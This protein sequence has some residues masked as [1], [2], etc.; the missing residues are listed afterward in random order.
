MPAKIQNVQRCK[1]H[2][3]Y[4]K[5]CPPQA[6]LDAAQQEV[7]A[8]K[9][10]LEAATLQPPDGGAGVLRERADALSAEVP[11]LQAALDHQRADAASAVAEAGELRAQLARLRSEQPTDGLAA[12]VRH[13]RSLHLGLC[14]Q[15]ANFQYMIASVFY[16]GDAFS[17]SLHC[18]GCIYGICGLRWTQLLYLA[19]IAC[20][21]VTFGCGG[22]LLR[23]TSYLS[24][25]FCTS[26][27]ALT[28]WWPRT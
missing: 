24:F 3:V 9:Q 11:R 12:G 23:H 10:Q 16:V 20:T 22:R 7:A 17:A 1:T 26:A 14:T 21:H 13:H 4:H 8:L 18:R 28:A 19:Y 5:S 2:S 25:S 6:E 15:V 27:L